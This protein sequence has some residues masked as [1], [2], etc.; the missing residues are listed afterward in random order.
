M[1][2]NPSSRSTTGHSARMGRPTTQPLPISRN[3]RVIVLL[4]PLFCV[5]RIRMRIDAHEVNPLIR[6]RIEKYWSRIQNLTEAQIERYF[7]ELRHAFIKGKCNT[8]RY[9]ATRHCYKVAINL[10]RGTVTQN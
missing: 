2:Q 4:H 6:I 8:V 5:F 7:G 1:P 3:R 10:S 9:T